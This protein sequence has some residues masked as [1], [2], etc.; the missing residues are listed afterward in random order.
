[1]SQDSST[2]QDAQHED[3]QHGDQGKNWLEWT[4]VVLGSLIV[5]A[6]AGYLAYETVRSGSAPPQ[7]VVDLGSPERH[8]DV[9]EVPLTVRNTGGRVARETTVEVCAAGPS[10][11]GTCALLTFDFVPHGSRRQGRV[12]LRT[13]L[14]DGL[15]SRIVSYREQ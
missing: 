13:P 2:K 7:L 8:G 14:A 4:V 15:Q 9:L 11:A 1:M 6:V 12:G 10:G 3:A 5:L